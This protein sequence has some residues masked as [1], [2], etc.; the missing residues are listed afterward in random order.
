M[1]YQNITIVI[2]AY[3]PSAELNSLALSLKATGFKNI[4]AIDDGGGQ[5]FA[6][7][8]TSLKGAEIDICTHAVNMGKGRALKTAFNHY[9]N[10]CSEDSIGILTVDADG[11]HKIEDI[12]RVADAFLKNQHKMVLGCREFAG[13]VPLR[14]R[15]GNSVTKFV[16]KVVSGNSL[17]DTQTGLRAIPKANLPQMLHFSG[18]RY[19]FEMQMLMELKNLKLSFVEIPI[20]TIYENNNESSHFNPL[21]DSWLIYKVILGFVAS[22]VLSFLVDYLLF[23]LLITMYPTMLIMAEIVSRVFSSL[24][25][26]TLNRKIL[27]SPHGKKSKVW[28]HLLK[29]YILAAVVLTADYYLISVLGM[30][31]ISVYLAKII[32]SILL[33]ALSFLIQKHVVFR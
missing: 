33:Y 7:I 32:A 26:F 6:H 31:G 17:S 18:E 15:F 16:Y 25:N 1:D 27:L 30:I 19:E 11:Q 14:S 23:S 13:E 10:T 4:I 9:L 20:K 22:S 3:K 12:L 29:Y 24:L 5:E 28:V 8:F 2:P 21:K